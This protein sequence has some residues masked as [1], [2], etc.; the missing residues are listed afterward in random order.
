MKNWFKSDTPWVWLNAG[1]LSLSIVM[2]VGLLGLIAVNGFAHFWASPVIETNWSEPGG[3]VQRVLGE[4]ADE[5]VLTAAAAKSAGIPV[6][7]DKKFVRRYLFKQGNRDIAGRDFVW[8]LESRLDPEWKTPDNVIMLERREWGNFY[9]YPVELLEA[10]QSVAQGE[11][12][13][14]ELLERLERSNDLF[15]RIREIERDDIGDINY[16]Q[17]QLRLEERRVELNNALSDQEKRELKAEIE[18]KRKPLTEQ[19]D[20]LR[21]ELAELDKKVSR[22]V[23]VAEVMDGNQ[24]KIPLKNIVRA[25]QPN[26]MSLFDKIGYYIERFVEFITDEPREANTEGGIF[27]AIF[28]TVTMVLL[29]TVFVTPFGILAAL[30]LREYAKQG[31]I[32]RII[33]ISVYNLAGV[34]SIVF[35]VFGVGFFVYFLGGILT[36]CSSPKPCRRPLSGPRGCSGYR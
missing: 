5:E 22:D 4:V 33:R 13:W 1:A 18:A 10:G 31:P 11:A 28:G 14:T 32:L 2:V 36:N 19:Y 15:A 9:G 17:E 12:V 27:P 16:R 8:Y 20:A 34:P 29:M 21:A 6:A 26:A 3:K 25:T 23:L 30:Y 7:E 24:V 35:G